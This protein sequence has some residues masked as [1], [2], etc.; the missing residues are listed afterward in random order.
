M[1]A[2]NLSP[3]QKMIN[4]MYL[5]LTALLALNV[6]KEVLNSF[7]EVNVGIERTTGNFDAK[8]N[9]TYIAFD[10]AFQNNPEKFK[11]VRDQ[12]YAVKAKT[13]DLVM[14]IQEMKYD[15]V[16]VVDNEKVYLGKQEDILD[17]EGKP[18][19]ELVIENKKFSDLTQ[20]QKLLPI[21]YLGNKDN[22]D[23]SGE[24]F[25]P[26]QITKEKRRA[27]ILKKMIEEYRDHLIG[28]SKGNQT[29]INNLNSS[30]DMSDKGESPKKITWEEYNFVDMP[31]VG[32]L[33]L[34]SKI[35]SDLRNAESNIIN[36][37]RTNIDAKALKFTSAEGLQISKKN[38]VLKGD[39]FEAE[40]FIAAKNESQ[41]PEIY[42]G[43]YDSLEN[44][45]YKMR[46][47]YQTVE[48]RNGKGYYTSRASSEG[49][50]KWG[51]LIAMKTESGTKYYPFEGE[52]LV[53]NKT[54]VVSPVK[55]NVLYLEVDNPV[56]ISV[57]G[58]PAADIT[59][60][61]TNGSITATQKTLGEY[62]A[63]PTKTGSA[64]ITL[65]ATVEGKKVKM[66]DVEFRVKD[67]P[68]PKPFIGGKSEGAIDKQAMIASGGIQAKLEDFDFEGIRY[69]V[70][71]YTLNTVYKGNEVEET[72]NGERFSE[73]INAIIN[74]AKSGNTISFSNIQARRTDAAGSATRALPPIVLKIK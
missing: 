50:K 66:G 53:A 27:V 64:T 5:V 12:A 19:E 13:D 34:L 9:E 30:F 57:P 51:G 15:L 65:F 54:A 29:L 52:Y 67:V 72:V 32:A 61:I 60:S 44:G 25:V 46:G 20:E 28:L 3:R 45:E 6:S 37:L 43:A 14:Y 7:F 42:V 73:K 2:G 58:F 55:M 33:T 4:M 39:L 56:K 68:P 36:Q 16:S 71:G 26:K 21:A 24:L 63:R 1:A 22:R 18:K 31:S 48:V 40:I 38:Y 70:V 49:V 59:A 47:D 11:E 23:M 74:N 69:K 8:N 41:N 17:E 35:Q 10:N 62:K